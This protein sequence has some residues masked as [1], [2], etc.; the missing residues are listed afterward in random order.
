MMN[1]K[2]FKKISVMFI[3]FIM[4]LNSGYSL[5]MSV[6]QNNNIQDFNS[7][8]NLNSI[9]YSFAGSVNNE[10]ILNNNTYYY[11]ERIELSAV[12]QEFYLW[13]NNY[14]INNS[15]TI[16]YF[17]SLVDDGNIYI[18]QMNLQE[19][20]NYYFK[21]ENNKNN[22]PAT[23]YISYDDNTFNAP[24]TLT[25][26]QPMG[27]NSLMGGFVNSFLDIVYININIWKIV[28][29]SLIF[30]VLLLFTVILFG[31]SFYIFKTIKKVNEQKGLMGLN[32]K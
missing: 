22:E 10:I 8:D 15:I 4:L 27:F 7:K 3:M 18:E 29:Y 14:I 11:D 1:S 2:K 30:G 16:M 17:G 19:R 28:F 25:T 5:T 31:G 12:N 32:K 20:G 9:V 6:N 23:I 26:K 13:F 24:M 21:F